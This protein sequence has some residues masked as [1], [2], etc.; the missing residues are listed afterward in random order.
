MTY[1]T[2]S[3]P[4]TGGTALYNTSMR[5]WA[6]ASIN[7]DSEDTHNCW[8]WVDEDGALLLPAGASPYGP[9]RPRLNWRPE[10]DQREPATNDGYGWYYADTG[11]SP[12]YLP[13]GP[14]RFR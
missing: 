11:E 4:A 9:M 3:I 10:Y 8:G 5:G 1:I 14:A 6:V 12:V 7:P 13:G 2:I